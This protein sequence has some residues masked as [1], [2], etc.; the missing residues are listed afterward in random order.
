MAVNRPGSPSRLGSLIKGRVAHGSAWPEPLAQTC[1][2]HFCKTVGYLCAQRGRWAGLSR[3]R[4]VTY[5]GRNRSMAASQD[6][7]KCCAA[8]P[9]YCPPT[10]GFFGVF[11]HWTFVSLGNC[12]WGMNCRF[13]HPGVNDKG[14]YSLIT[15]AEPF[16][17]NGAPPLG[18]HPLM[19]A[20]PWVREL[21]CS[22][23]QMG[24]PSFV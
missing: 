23:H 9:S 6:V 20:N 4:S 15:K 18:P 19:P 2:A 24:H 8:H 14:N 12:T 21:L 3:Q 17:P 1:P 10:V 16:P 11:S 13:I 5:V 7:S 22:C